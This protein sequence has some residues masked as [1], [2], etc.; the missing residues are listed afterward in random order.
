MAKASPKL[1]ARL[2]AP[3]DDCFWLYSS[4]S[5]GRPKGAVHAQRDMVV[6]SELY[7]TRVLGVTENDICYSAAKLFF[8]YGL[9]NAMTFPLWAG[10][11]AILD[12]RRPTPDVTFENIERFK[13]TLYLRRADALRRPAGGARCHA[14]PARQPARLRLG[15]RG[16]ARRHLPPLEGEDRHDHPR[17]HRL[18]RV[19]A[20]LHRQPARRLPP[21]HLGQAGAGLRDQGARRQAPAGERRA[22]AARCGSAPSRPPNTTGTSPRRP[23]RRWSTAG[24]TPATPTAR[25]PT[26]S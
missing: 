10:G 13:P 8:A 23:P 9:G 14:A 3:T 4:G 20:H 21:R 5:T 12:D 17:R 1:E 19:P 18:D 22:R 25:T 26:A 24:S 7:G 2:A 11:T 16:A 6:T 15:R